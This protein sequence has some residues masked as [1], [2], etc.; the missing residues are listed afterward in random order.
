MDT[1]VPAVLDEKEEGGDKSIVAT[2]Q[3][4]VGEGRFRERPRCQ[5]SYSLRNIPKNGFSK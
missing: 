2:H 1:S 5:N 3:Q 4:Q